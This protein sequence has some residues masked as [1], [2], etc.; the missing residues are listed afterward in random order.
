[1]TEV[2]FDICE[3]VFYLNTASGKIEGEEIK[4]I[5]IVPTGIS[6]DEEG[7]NVLDG[8]V[9]LYQTV[10]GAVLS[11]SEVFSDEVSCREYWLEKLK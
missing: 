10:E 6:K 4:G 9:V 11:E 2:R 3:R 7:R 1:M 5:Q 8:Q